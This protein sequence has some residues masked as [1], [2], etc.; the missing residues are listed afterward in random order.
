[1]SNKSKHFIYLNTKALKASFMEG[2]NYPRRA[3]QMFSQKSAHTIQ[4]TNIQE[5]PNFIMYLKE[6]LLS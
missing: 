5:K 6:S 3:Y 2:K 1:M 4:Y